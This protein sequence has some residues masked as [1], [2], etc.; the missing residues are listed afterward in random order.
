MSKIVEG[1]FSGVVVAT[2]IPVMYQINKFVLKSLLGFNVAI[3]R[4][5]INVVLPPN[6]QKPPMT[7]EERALRLELIEIAKQFL[8]NS[9]T[10]E[11]VR[12]AKARITVRK[13]LKA[14]FVKK[15]KI[16]KS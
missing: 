6:P 5:I 8:T 1:F 15:K 14:R 7:E 16:K 9:L 10:D 4:T 13:E 3:G 11:T 2:V 12:I